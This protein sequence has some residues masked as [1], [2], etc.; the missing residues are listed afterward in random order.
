M[1]VVL[2]DTERYPVFIWYDYDME[3]GGWKPE[4]ATEVD[5]ATI[6]RWQ[7]VFDAFDVVQKE[8]SEMLRRKT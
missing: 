8:I 4:D 2:S 6:A 5:D 1:K 7:A 3:N